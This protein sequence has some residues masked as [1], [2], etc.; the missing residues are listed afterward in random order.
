MLARTPAEIPMAYGFRTKFALF[1]L[2]SMGAAAA[3]AAPTAEVKEASQATTKEE[4][5]EAGPPASKTL[6][7]AK[8]LYDHGD[9]PSA[10]IE[11]DKAM[12]GNEDSEP[13]KQKA[14]FFLGKSLFHLRFYAAALVYFDNIVQ[15]GPS[16]RYYRRTL[17]WLAALAEVLPE[18]AGILKKIGKYSMDDL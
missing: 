7:R 13:N 2:M 10:T 16:H 18:S 5:E 8:K 9:Y 14:E 1:C 4:A 11:F 3:Q 17:Q 12:K 6:E 15:K